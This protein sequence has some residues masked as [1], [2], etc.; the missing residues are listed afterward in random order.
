M[1]PQILS[2]N[3]F[4]IISDR[5]LPTSI[6]QIRIPRSFSL[7]FNHGPSNASGKD[8][9]YGIRKPNH[10]RCQNSTK[11]AKILCKKIQYSFLHACSETITKF[12]LK[13]MHATYKPG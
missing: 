7:L 11:L 6:L 4:Y 1:K 8:E 3:S 2:N 5:P 13:K 12:S 10:Q 9:S